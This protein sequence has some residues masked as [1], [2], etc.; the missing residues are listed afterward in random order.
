MFTSKRSKELKQRETKC[1][2]KVERVLKN[3]KDKDNIYGKMEENKLG[4]VHRLV[5]K[6]SYLSWEEYI[7]HKEET[8]K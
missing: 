7:N 6:S 4:L 3:K 5:A 1:M 2:D 8:I